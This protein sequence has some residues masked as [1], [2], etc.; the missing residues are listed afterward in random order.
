MKQSNTGHLA[1]GFPYVFPFDVSAPP[2]RRSGFP[3]MT[4]RMAACYIAWRPEE[5]YF[6][7]WGV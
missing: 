5:G 6:A 4:G 3:W 7:L 2:R 1:A